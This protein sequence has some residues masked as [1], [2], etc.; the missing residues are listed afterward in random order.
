MDERGLLATSTDGNSFLPPLMV[1]S[2]VFAD[3]IDLAIGGG[4]VHFVWT[5][6]DGPGTIIYNRAD[7][8]LSSAATS[9]VALSPASYAPKIAAGPNGE[10]QRCGPPTGITGARTELV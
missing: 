9:P 7:I 8:S 2:D 3:Q 10:L 6:F 5:Y 4:A 1:V